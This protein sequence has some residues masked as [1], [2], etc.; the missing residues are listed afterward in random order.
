M[1][2]INIFDDI[3]RR[4]NQREGAKIVVFALEDNK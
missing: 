2:T 4:P 1:K 3:E